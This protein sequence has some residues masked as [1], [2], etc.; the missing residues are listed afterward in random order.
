MFK[1]VVDSFVDFPNKVSDTFGVI[2]GSLGSV[3]KDTVFCVVPFL[4]SQLDNVL[5]N[6]HSLKFELFLVHREPPV[7]FWP[8]SPLGDF[9]PDTPSPSSLLPNAPSTPGALKA[10]ASAGVFLSIIP[11][12]LGRRVTRRKEGIYGRTGIKNPLEVE[13]CVKKRSK[14]WLLS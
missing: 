11:S 10:L 13:R 4:N 12:S 1:R 2:F 3:K 9:T 6:L 5:R 14:T 7:R 8:F